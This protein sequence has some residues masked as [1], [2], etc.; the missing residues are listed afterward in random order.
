MPRQDGVTK[1]RMIDEPGRQLNVGQ[2]RYVRLMRAMSDRLVRTCRFVDMR[3]I[4]RRSHC[5]F[6]SMAMGSAF[7]GRHGHKPKARTFAGSTPRIDVSNRSGHVTRGQDGLPDIH[8]E[9]V[10]S[11]ETYHIH[12]GDMTQSGPVS[13][14]RKG[15]CTPNERVDHSNRRLRL[16]KGSVGD[17]ERPV[18]LA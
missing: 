4:R 14:R 15:D 12:L 10:A 7:E 9:V 1:N 13:Q 16:V 2:I 8:I 6:A 3:S 5:C 18:Q 11:V 17:C